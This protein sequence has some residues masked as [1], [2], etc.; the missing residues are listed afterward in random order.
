MDVMTEEIQWVC[1]ACGHN[2]FE[3]INGDKVCCHCDWIDKK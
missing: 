3:V 1:S 2:E